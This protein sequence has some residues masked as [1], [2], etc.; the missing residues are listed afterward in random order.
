MWKVGPIQFW[1][2]CVICLNNYYFFSRGK[3]PGKPR[4]NPGKTPGKLGQ[5]LENHGKTPHVTQ[6]KIIG[7]LEMKLTE[8]F[9]SRTLKLF[10]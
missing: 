6:T 9:R 1:R 7:P 10:L 8:F 5:T 3:T 2:V 4:E